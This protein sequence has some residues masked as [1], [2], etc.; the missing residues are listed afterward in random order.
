MRNLLNVY[1]PK[2]S[3]HYPFFASIFYYLRALQVISFPI[4]SKIE[5]SWPCK[6]FTNMAQLTYAAH[7]QASPGTASVPALGQSWH[8]VKK[9]NI[10]INPLGFDFQ[11][12]Y[13]PLTR[14]TGWLY[15]IC[16]WKCEQRWGNKE[17]M[18]DVPFA[19]DLFV[20]SL[21]LKG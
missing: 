13:M 1:P 9:K 12:L 6:Y 20:C 5:N 14:M 3:C 7:S 10:P 16:H 2:P 19:V 17:E 21:L 4:R 8:C 18:W 15:E 11:M